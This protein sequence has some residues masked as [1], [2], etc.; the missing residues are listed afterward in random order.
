MKSKITSLLHEFLDSERAG[1]I[2]LLICTV[3]SL[4]IANS[5]AGEGYISFWHRHLDLSVASIDLDLSMEQWINDGLMAMFFLLVGLEIER[6]LYVGELSDFRVAALP[7]AAAI[8]GLIVPALIHFSFNHNLPTRAGLGIPMA[9][10]IAFTLGMLS[11]L[12]NRVPVALKIFLTALAII[13]DLGAILVIAI[14]YNTGINW[15]YLFAALGILGGLYLLGKRGVH[16]LFIYVLL[17]IVAWYCMMKSGVH[18]TISGVLLAFVIPFGKG[19][20]KSLS[21]RL[22]H[23]LHKPVAFFIL[24]IFA[25]ANTGILLTTGWQHELVTS[26]GLGIILGLLIGKPVGILLFS[27]IL[28]R[29]KWGNLPAS[30]QWKHLAGAGILAGIGFTMSIFI[31]NLAFDNAETILFSKA[32]VLAGSIC[33]LVAGLAW[34]HFSLNQK[35]EQTETGS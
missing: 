8:G 19:G 12:G 33:S 11:L 16:R 10:D 7:I 20:K 4:L 22:Q 30:V 15:I 13:D 9:T 29:L 5:N 35:N 6:E 25:L 17:G 27:F 3:A 34:L 28:V 32:A 1:G 18:A 2:I 23:S 24:P 26:N 14:F 31:A 21:A